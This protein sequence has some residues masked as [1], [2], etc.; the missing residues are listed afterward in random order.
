MNI[1]KT[2]YENCL[3][4]IS[5]KIKTIEKNIVGI[6]ESLLSETKS[7]AG[8]KHETGRAMLQIEREKAGQQL[9]EVEKL[10][11]V[12]KKIDYDFV[13]R[14]VGLG[15][16]VFTTRYNYFISVS[17]GE[18]CIENQSF[19]AISSQTPI[20]RLLRGKQVGDLIEFNGR[21]FEILK[22]I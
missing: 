7:S 4:Q 2:L 9:L 11:H 8:D 12:L 19:Y 3:T 18:I 5:F 15:S 10:K 13:S 1:K 17:M 20:G 14:K 16:V 21:T 22:V 6:E